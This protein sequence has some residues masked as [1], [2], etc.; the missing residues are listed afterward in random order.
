MANI[1]MKRTGLIY[2]LT[3]PAELNGEIGFSE[4]DDLQIR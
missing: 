1:I 3:R 2:L 4:H